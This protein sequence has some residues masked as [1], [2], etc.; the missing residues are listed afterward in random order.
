MS[1]MADVLDQKMTGRSVEQ[2][3]A[4]RVLAKSA[5][6]Q[7]IRSAVEKLLAQ[8]PTATPRPRSDVGC[9]RRAAR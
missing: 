8:A 9:G 2:Q 6:L 1:R 5:S 4:A 3:G 7:E